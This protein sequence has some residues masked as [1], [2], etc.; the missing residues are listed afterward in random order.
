ME[1]KTPVS[2]NRTSEDIY[3][4]ALEL[5]RSYCPELNIPDSA[6]YFD[7]DDN[8]AQQNPGQTPSCVP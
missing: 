4:Q 2:D 7:P 5:A 3:N 6:S 1:I 8:T